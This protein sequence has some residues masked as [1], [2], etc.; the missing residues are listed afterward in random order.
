MPRLAARH[1]IDHTLLLSVQ[2]HIVSQT[3]GIRIAVRRQH[4]SQHRTANPMPLCRGSHHADENPEGVNCLFLGTFL[5]CLA[6]TGP[7]IL[8]TFT[9]RLQ[10]G[11]ASPESVSLP[12]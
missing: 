5:P 2:G 7:S 9:M 10:L 1:W 6:R 12:T 11:I 4:S 8:A 3:S